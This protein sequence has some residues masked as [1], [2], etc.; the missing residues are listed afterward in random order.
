VAADAPREGAPLNS[1]PAWL[2]V[3]MRSS[4]TRNSAES[5]RFAALA[6]EPPAVR[7][8]KPHTDELSELLDEERNR[9]GEYEA[10]LF[11]RIL[12]QLRH[13]RAVLRVIHDRYLDFCKA[14]VE[15]YP[16]L[17]AV[18][19]PGEP[20]TL[21]SALL[22]TQKDLTVLLRLEIESFYLFGKI[23]LDWFARFVEFYFGP[24]RGLSLASHDKLTKNIWE[25]ARTKGLSLPTGM[26]EACLSLRENLSDIR[27]Y[28]VA[29]QK[30]L[31]VLDAYNFTF[32]GR[33]RLVYARMYPTPRDERAETQPLDQLLTELG[34]YISLIIDLVRRNRAKTALTVAPR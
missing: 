33:V 12:D 24:G 22:T 5:L 27:D 6:A 29:H 18:P 20:P 4:A 26:V 7:P 30:N 8:M 14:Y 34:K 32:E 3:T 11:V 25:Y 2:E 13:Y 21:D 17:F 23:L 10:N 19:P 9:F 15:N 16:V 28:Q 1:A 31:R